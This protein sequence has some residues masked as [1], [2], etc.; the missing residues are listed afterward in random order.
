MYFIFSYKFIRIKRL[1]FIQYILIC[2][3][4]TM[5]SKE[6]YWY[7]HLDIFPGGVPFVYLSSVMVDFKLKMMSLDDTSSRPN[8][9]TDDQFTTS[10]P[11][12]NC[13]EDTAKARRLVRKRNIQRREL[14]V[15]QRRN[16]TEN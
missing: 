6:K 11:H 8:S 7:F 5:V 9:Q 13:P 3:V 1:L 16:R 12:C 14:D 2:L 15:T 10:S 4:V